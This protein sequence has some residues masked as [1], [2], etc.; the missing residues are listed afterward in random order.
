[1]GRVT[2]NFGNS[3]SRSFAHWHLTMLTFAPFGAAPT[4][5][6]ALGGAAA[7]TEHAS[8]RVM[9]AADAAAVL[10]F[11][12]VSLGGLTAKLPWANIACRSFPL[13]GA[14][15]AAGASAVHVQLTHRLLAFLLLLHLI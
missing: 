15:P 4:G 5:A 11:L 10:A 3:P 2:V 14:D 6:G 8:L 1:S 12:A 7:A 13:C 9:R